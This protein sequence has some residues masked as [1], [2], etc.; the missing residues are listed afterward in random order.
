MQPSGKRPKSSTFAHLFRCRPCPSLFATRPGVTKMV[1]QNTYPVH[2]YAG[3]S[4]RWNLRSSRE[5]H[6]FDGARGWP[7]CPPRPRQ[8]LGTRGALAGTRLCRTKKGDFSMQQLLTKK[9]SRGFT[10]IELMIVVVII[11]VLA[12]L[13]IYGVQKYVN[14]SKTGE[15]RNAIGRLQKAAVGAYEGETMPGALIAV[16][17][18]IGA[19]RRFCNSVAAADY[20]PV[21]V[22]AGQKY[23][24]SEDNWATGDATTGWTCLKFSMK[25]PQ[26]YQYRY[27]A[28][29]TAAA[30]AAGDNFLIEAL[31][32]LDGDT[33]N[34]VF[35]SLGDLVLSATGGF[36]LRL[37]PAIIE[38]L[39]DE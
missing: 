10:L 22:P 7:R 13:A 25:G 29:N 20:V 1:H 24:S 5:K 18:Q 2:P 34:S 17:T 6:G 23:Q 26:Y 19:S 36:T 11:G 4:D 3:F 8:A 15:A 21:A 30:P 28:T 9:K 35:S 37:S 14:A 38:T 39:P 31:G 33:T 27:T 32:D 16:N 12:S